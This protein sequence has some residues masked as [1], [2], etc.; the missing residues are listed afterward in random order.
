MMPMRHG[1]G[2]VNPLVGGFGAGLPSTLLN[3]GTR[4]Q[5]LGQRQLRQGLRELAL[6]RSLTSQGA[7]APPGAGIC[8]SAIS[9]S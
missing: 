1:Y 9:S 4:L 6:S 2:W 5:L 3:Q 8:R 7:T